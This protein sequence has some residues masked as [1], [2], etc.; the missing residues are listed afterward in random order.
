M[1]YAI[2]ALIVFAAIIPTRA[3]DGSCVVSAA[4]YEN[5]HYIVRIPHGE[6][7][8]SLTASPPVTLIAQHYIT[9]TYVLTISSTPLITTTI[10]TFDYSET[11]TLL[12]Y[13]PLT[14]RPNDY[15]YTLQSGTPFRV[16]S[17]AQAIHP[18]IFLPLVGRPAVNAIAARRPV[19]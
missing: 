3:Q 12:G 13:E 11:T 5:P 9:D 1:R 15:A 10:W 18:H 19:D 8:G 7:G 17:C 16:W 2:I 14:P 4:S 6:V